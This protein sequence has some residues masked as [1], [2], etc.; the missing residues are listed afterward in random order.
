MNSVLRNRYLLLVIL[1]AAFFRFFLINQF[2]TGITNDEIDSII[3]AK[4]FFLSGQILKAPKGELNHVLI[5]PIVGPL[6][7]SLGVA[8]LPYALASVGTVVVLFLI[9][10]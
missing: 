9:V 8:R 4:S 7:F 3:N 6:P 2:P 10:D 1:L 5:A